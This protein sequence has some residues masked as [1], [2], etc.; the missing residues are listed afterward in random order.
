MDGRFVSPPIL[1][2]SSPRGVDLLAF[3]HPNPNHPVSRW[4]LGDGQAA[5]PVVF[6]EHTAALSL[7]ALAGVA[8]AVWRAGYRPHPAWWW[9]LAGSAALALGPFVIVAGTNSHVPGPWALLRYVPLVS[10]VRTPTR[11]AL[12]AALGAAILLAGALAALGALA[13][14]APGDARRS[15]WHSS[16]S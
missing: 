3:L 8:L 15:C 2:R 5:A 10:A 4:L 14:S 9:M 1:W 7:V 6:V 13:A 16:S 12:V 11:F